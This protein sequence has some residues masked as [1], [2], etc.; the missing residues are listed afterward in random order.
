MKKGKSQQKRRRRPQ[1]QI[2]NSA[3]KMAD[4]IRKNVIPKP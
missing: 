3:Q 1:P 2:K 4:D